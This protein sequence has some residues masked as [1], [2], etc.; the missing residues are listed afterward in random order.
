MI[1]MLIFSFLMYDIL[2]IL[3]QNGFWCGGFNKEKRSMQ[4]KK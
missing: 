1:S 4:L 3:A 2:D